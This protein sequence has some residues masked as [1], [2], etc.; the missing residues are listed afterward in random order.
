VPPTGTIL[1]AEDEALV[2]GV[3]VRVL[4]S[5]GYAV[6]QA[7]DGEQ[8]L[9]LVRAHRT[10][11]DLVITDVVMARMGG[12]D[13]AKQLSVERPSLPVLLISGYSRKELLDDPAHPIGSLRK[14]FT[15][16]ELL[17]RVAS[18]LTVAGRPV[19]K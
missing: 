2:R 12:L 7:Q 8:A 16:S 18:L 14:P 13:L 5:A 19:R 9:D 1:V 3:V 17:E 11:I 6:I 4:G 15:P 10:P